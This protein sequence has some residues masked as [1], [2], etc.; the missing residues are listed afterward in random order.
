MAA[1]WSLVTDDLKS[2]HGLAFDDEDVLFVAEA[3]RGRISRIDEGRVHAFAETGGKPL[4]IAFDDSGDIFVAESARHHLLLI[5]VDEAVEVYA[6]QCRGERIVAPQE[7]C[8]SPEG[9]ILFTDSGRD[10]KTGSVYRADIDGEVNRVASGLSNPTGMVWSQD[11]TT[12]YVS[13]TGKR[14]IIS[15]E[16]DDAGETMVNQQTLVTFDT[17][18]PRALIF[19]SQGNLYVALHGVGLVLIDDAGETQETMEVGAGEPA[20]LIFGGLNYDELYVSDVGSGSVFCSQRE[21]S[22]QRPFAGP[23]SV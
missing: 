12:L 19:D 15:L 13:E 14:R 23:R 3:E 20:G 4:G 16:L 2:P 21:I 17:G 9:D 22:G 18:E 11:A 7:L 5:S 6:N 10:G 8:F 1:S